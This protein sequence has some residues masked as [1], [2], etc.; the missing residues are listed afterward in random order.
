MR[1]SPAS[2]VLRLLGVSSLAERR[3]HLSTDSHA[4]PGPGFVLAALPCL[5]YPWHI[6]DKTEQGRVKL[7]HTGGLSDTRQGRA[8]GGRGSPAGPEPPGQRAE[9]PCIGGALGAEGRQGAPTPQAGRAPAPSTEP[10]S[11]PPGEV[12]RAAALTP[13]TV[14]TERPS[15]AQN[16]VVGP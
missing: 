16:A 7:R 4:P 3:G 15:V 1:S 13:V 2:V 6:P 12:T 10:R 5:E 8:K 9:W 11:K 14:C